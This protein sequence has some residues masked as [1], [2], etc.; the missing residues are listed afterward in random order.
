[1]HLIADEE[2]QE[3]DGEHHRERPQ[4]REPSRLALSHPREYCHDDFCHRL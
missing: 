2:R 3:R 1:V 4:R